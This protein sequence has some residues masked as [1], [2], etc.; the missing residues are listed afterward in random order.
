MSYDALY[1]NYPDHYTVEE[2]KTG[3]GGHVNSSD[4][5]NTC[6]IRMSRALNYSGYP[7][8]HNHPG[9]TTVSGTD[10]K[11]YAFRMQELKKYLITRFGPP[12]LSVTKGPMSGVDR[13][14][15]AGKKGII[16]FDIVFPAN[17]GEHDDA[18]GHLDLWDG[19]HF[20][21]E[22][23]GEDYFARANGCRPLGNEIKT[24]SRRKLARYCAGKESASSLPGAI[25]RQRPARK[26]GTE[27]LYGISSFT[28]PA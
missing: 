19:S 5:K 7:L 25:T 14:K 13:S 22:H 2:V 16:A 20:T 18:Y 10:K 17:P 6:A 3:I 4:F 24:K 8:P 1:R 12:S 23:P 9:L 27:D 11:W 28:C 21:Q 15:F 26:A